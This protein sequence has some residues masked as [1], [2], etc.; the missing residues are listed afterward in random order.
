MLSCRLVERTQ[1]LASCGA[2][3]LLSELLTSNRL[4][5]T[6]PPDPLNY[7]TPC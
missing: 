7:S 6:H 4:L 3:P 5:C 1:R 2:W